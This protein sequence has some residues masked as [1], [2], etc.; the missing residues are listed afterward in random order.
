VNCSLYRA[1]AASL[2]RT[3]A[4]I[5]N[6][7]GMHGIPV[8]QWMAPCKLRPIIDTVF[9]LSEAREA[10]WRLATGRISARC[11]SRC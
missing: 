3:P 8:L 10:F 4:A 7:A 11:A 5:R 1:L 9:P 6:E 2:K